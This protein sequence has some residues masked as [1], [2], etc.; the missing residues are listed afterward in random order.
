MKISVATLP[1]YSR[2]SLTTTLLGVLFLCICSYVYFVAAAVLDAV[3]ERDFAHRASTVQSEI[4]MLE[5]KQMVARHEISSRI[6]VLSEV[7]AAETPLFVSRD[8]TS[9]ALH[10]SFE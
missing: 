1:N 4:S 5:S 6:A 9:V 2:L 3:V 7:A 8:G 10:K